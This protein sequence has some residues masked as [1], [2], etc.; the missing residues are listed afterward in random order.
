MRPMPDDAPVLDLSAVEPDQ[1]ALTYGGHRDND[2]TPGV[3][4]APDAPVGLMGGAR[5]MTGADLVA[6]YRRWGLTVVQVRRRGVSW[7]ANNRPGNYGPMCGQV[8]HHTG[9]YGTVEG[10]LA[11]LFEGRS[12]LPGGLCTDG[13]APNGTVYMISGGRANHAGKGAGNVYSALRDDRTPG[14]PG[15]DAADGNAVL[16]G[17]EVMNPG[18]GATRYPD[19]QFEALVRVQAARAQ[20]H[21]WDGAHSIRHGGWT[22]RKIDTRGTTAHGD[23]ITQDFLQREV[24]RALRLGP[25]LYAYPA[26]D[27]VARLTTDDVKVILGT[28][29]D[30]PQWVQTRYGL[31]ADA[32]VEDLLIGACAHAKAAEDG[33]DDFD[34]D[35]YGGRTLQQVLVDGANA[36]ARLAAASGDGPAKG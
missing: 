18:D 16:Y 26:G 12:D 10:M 23:T 36:A 15:P 27:I 7:R 8:A 3:G 2:A 14:P 20:W 9:P 4:L 32:T 30:I 31:P 11:L 5:P 34:R 28:Q 22:T 24:A 35:T 25:D 19:P 33:G 21:G 1:V 17:D 29:V 6:A 13:I